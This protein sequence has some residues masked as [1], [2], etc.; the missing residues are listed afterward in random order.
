MLND[1]LITRQSGQNGKP[2][3]RLYLVEK[4]KM[5]KEMYVSIMLD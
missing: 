5:T 2:V 1:V 4:V 3:N